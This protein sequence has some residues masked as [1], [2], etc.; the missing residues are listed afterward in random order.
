MLPCRAG[1]FF[2]V[3]CLKSRN[4]RRAGIPGVN[5]RID[6]P[7]DQPTDDDSASDAPTPEKGD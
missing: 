6:I 3:Q 2:I 4:Y 5:N 7:H 1:L